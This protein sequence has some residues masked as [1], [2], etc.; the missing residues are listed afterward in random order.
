MSYGDNGN[1]NGGGGAYLSTY[2][3]TSRYLLG[4]VNSANLGAGRTSVDNIDLIW[5]TSNQYEEGIDLSV[6]NYTL[7]IVIDYFHKEVKDMLLQL[8]LPNTFGYPNFPW[9]NSGS[10]DNKGVEVSVIHRNSFGSFNF[11]VKGNISS[12][13]NEIG[14]AHV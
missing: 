7:D 5:E 6:F 2:G 9:V 3:N 11:E 14:R 8:P 13:K 1:Q 4:N 12:F 10:M